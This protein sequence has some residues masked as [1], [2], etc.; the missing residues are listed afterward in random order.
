[1]DFTNKAKQSLQNLLVL[2]PSKN[3][4]HKLKHP[5]SA[6]LLETLSRS[7]NVNT[8]TKEKYRKENT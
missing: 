3:Q 2:E 5:I 1:M 7:T 6:T 8:F 4:D